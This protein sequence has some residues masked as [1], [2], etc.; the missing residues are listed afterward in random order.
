[1]RFGTL[2]DR[3]ETMT[4]K[5]GPVETYSANP[6]EA[7][8]YALLQRLAPAFRHRMV[9]G[10]H[11]I[12]LIVEVVEQRLQEAAPDLANARENLGKIKGLSRSAVLSC[13]NVISWLAPDEAAVTMLGEGID[14]CLALISTDFDMRGFAVRNEARE[15]GVD[16]SRTALRNVLTA[17]LIAATDAATQPSDLVLTTELS[18]GHALVSIVVCPA[19]R[20]AGFSDAAAYRRIEWGDVAALA[21]SKSV[22]LLRQGD[23]LS[24]RYALAGV[25]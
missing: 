18:Q 16:V 5:S 3:A 1:V 21:Q 25:A 10:L 4:M 12:E 23:R 11:P 22:D 19:D 2:R 8:S 9:G 6:A 24:M 15:I 17:A 14:E 7:A 13:T 20:A